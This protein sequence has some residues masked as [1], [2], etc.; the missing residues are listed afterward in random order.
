[1]DEIDALITRYK[2]MVRKKARGYYLP[3]A[4]MEDLIQ[5]GMI[6][7]YKAIR[8]FRPEIGISFDYFA[9]LCTERQIKSAV[10]SSLR[11]QCGFL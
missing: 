11:E 9:E 2:P 4:D 1:M 10:R 5:E 8:N 3:G 6:G 7:L